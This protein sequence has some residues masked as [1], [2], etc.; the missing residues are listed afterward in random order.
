MGARWRSDIKD[1]PPPIGG[2]LLSLCLKLVLLLGEGS[3][4]PL[5]N[6]QADENNNPEW[7]FDLVVSHDR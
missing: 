6:R 2:C 4:S 7:R 1:P 5:E 3:D